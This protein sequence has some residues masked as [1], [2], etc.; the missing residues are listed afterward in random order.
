RVYLLLRDQIIGGVL[1]SGSRLPSEPALALDH[2]VSRVTIRRALD[3]LATDGLIE[4]KPGSGTFVRDGVGTPRIVGD[5]ANVLPHLVEMG[6]QTSVRLLA[7]AYVVPPV[8]VATALR[9]APRERAQR[10]LRIRLIDGR[11]F[12]YLTTYVPER[13]GL[14]YSEADLAR[15]PLLEL[16]ERSGV[17]ASRASQSIGAALAGPEVAGALK[18]EI[19]SPL[20][21][22]TRVVLDEKDQGV[23]HLHAL[24]RPDLYSLQIDLVRTGTSGER[25]W[26]PIAHCVDDSDKA[27]APS[28]HA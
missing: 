17:S 15:T 23:E 24:Y 20:I 19:G 2:H 21:S 22:L 26:T 10:S 3:Q 4:R 13:I 8:P 27:S 6:R 16:L 25:R 18:L 11:P 12:S 7:F 14:S 28:G 1:A 9:L 5:L